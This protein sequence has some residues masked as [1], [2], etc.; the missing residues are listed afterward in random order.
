MTSAQF[1]WPVTCCGSIEKLGYT[2]AIIPVVIVIVIVNQMDLH[3]INRPK[4]YQKFCHT[5]SEGLVWMDWKG[6]PIPLSH[7]LG[8][9]VEAIDPTEL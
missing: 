1:G 9:H 7:T 4:D 2:L 6:N 5:S 3:K 8:A